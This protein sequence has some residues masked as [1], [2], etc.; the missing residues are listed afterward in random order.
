SLAGLGCFPVGGRAAEQPPTA[1]QI[2]FF[3]TSIRPLFVQHCFKCHGP[4]KQRAGLRLDSRDALL[5]GGRS[6][7][8]ATPGRPDSSL[9]LRAVRYRD[10]ELKMP[11]QGK[12]SD[13]QIADLTRWVQMGV[14]FPPRAATA[15]VPSAR[16]HWAFRAPADPA[17]P[18]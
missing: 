18:A 14:P 10:D 5:R 17:L 11:P 12:L 1:E 15:K 7:A 13:R 6:G 8:A 3:E 2:R 16:D 4:D 9:L